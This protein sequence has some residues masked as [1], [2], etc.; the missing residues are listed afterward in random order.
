MLRVCSRGGALHHHALKRVDAGVFRVVRF[1]VRAA[2]RSQRGESLAIPVAL[3]HQCDRTVDIIG[4]ARV[5]AVCGGDNPQPIVVAVEKGEHRNPGREKTRELARYHGCSVGGI[6]T[7]EA[8]IKFFHEGGICGWIHKRFEL[9][10]AQPFCLCA[11]HEALAFRSVAHEEED[12]ILEILCA[13]R[14]LQDEVEVLCGS[15]NAGESNDDFLF[16]SVSSAECASGLRG[17]PGIEVNPIR[18]D[19]YLRCGDLLLLEEE[20]FAA[21]RV[22]GD[23]IGVRVRDALHPFEICNERAVAHDAEIDGI[24]RED[25]LYVEEVW[26]AVFAGDRVTDLRER[27]GR[28]V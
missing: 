2:R 20:C 14:D 11:R 9:H 27:E 12:E 17:A 19:R 16:E 10:V 15:E 6:E 23:D 7:E 28:D 26:G 13:S 1:R 18:Y 8:D 22:G 24:L 25:V 4:Y 21:F 5:S 3:P